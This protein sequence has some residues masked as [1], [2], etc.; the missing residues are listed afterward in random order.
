MERPGD[1]FDRFAR[2]IPTS[3]CRKTSTFEPASRPEARDRFKIL[4]LNLHN[5]GLS[6][7]H[8]RRRSRI[9]RPCHGQRRGAGSPGSVAE[10]TVV[11]ASPAYD[12]AVGRQ[13]AALMLVTG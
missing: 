13:H 11:V 2:A 8:R 6:R 4:K 5:A 10:L 1:E 12:R 7:A 3:R 9:G